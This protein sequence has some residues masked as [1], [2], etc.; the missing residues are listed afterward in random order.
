MKLFFSLFAIL[1]CC[2][3]TA[4]IPDPNNPLVQQRARQELVDRGLTEAE[5]RQRLEAEGID[6]DNARPDQL[7]RIQE[8]IDEMEAE[9]KN[10]GTGI[11]RPGEPRAAPPTTPQP[12]SKPPSKSS[13][14]PLPSQFTPNAAKSI[15]RAI[16]DGAT[17]QEAISEE[18]IDAAAEQDTSLTQEARIYGH[19]FFRNQN[20]S[21]FRQS[22]NVKV[23]PS[24]ILGAG[25]EI[26][27][28]IFGPSVESFTYE[29]SPG[30]FIQPTQMPRITLKGVTIEEARAILRRQFSRFYVFGTG[31]FV[32]TLNTARTIRVNIYGEVLRRGS[33]TV[34]AINNAYNALAAS[35]G[36]SDIG[37]VRNIQINR[38]AESSTTVDL[39]DFLIAGNPIT[40][41]LALD[42]NDY[43]FVPV[44]DRVV[45]IEGAVQR[46]FAYELKAG[47]QL[48]TLLRFAG[49]LAE[50][51]YAG[52]ITVRRFAG[53]RQVVLDVD[54]ETLRSSGADFT[55]KPGDRVRV[56]QQSVRLRGSAQV[57]GAV[58][59]PDSYGVGENLRLTQ[60]LQ[61]AV[62]AE[63]AQRQFVFLQRLNP[64]STYNFQSVALAAA[65]AA[66]G[67]T[68]DVNIQEGDIV[69]VLSQIR[70]SALGTIRVQGAVENPI[71][72]FP[73]DAS[74]TLR[75]SDAIY[76]A[77]GL[78]PDATS[79]AY[80]FRTDPTNPSLKQYIGVDI[81][82]IMANP[83]R[84][85]NII[86]QA[87]DIVRI[88]DR[89]RYTDRLT[90]QVSGEVRQPDEFAFAEGATLRDAI[91]LAG[92]LLF[93]ADPSR[94]EVFRTVIREGESVQT[95]AA[96]V[97]VDVDVETTTAADFL[98]EPFDKIYV[99]RIP[100][101]DLEE[102]IYIG[103]EVRY[104]GN[105]P[106]LRDNERLVDVI[107]RAGGLTDE[108]FPPGATL[109][110]NE[111]EVG[112]IVM[113]LERALDDPAVIDNI[114]LREG[115][116]I[117]IPKSKDLVI[118]QGA[119][120]AGEF[121]PG[122]VT[123]DGRI[124]TAYR[125]NGKRAR[126]YLNE[127][128][129][130]PAENAD[131]RRIAVLHP[132]GEIKRTKNI[133]FFRVTPKV[134]RGSIVTVPVKP[135]KIQDPN[136]PDR[137]K[138]DWGKVIADSI[139]QATAILSLVLLVQQV[140]R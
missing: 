140:N 116:Q 106:L 133:L 6:L 7:P 74:G 8:I 22:D 85:D 59:Y 94:V 83:D 66:P 69:T 19:Q 51:A 3:L 48:N 97:D 127:F 115:D 132:N 138:V 21:V 136:D 107:Q 46:P 80:V 137:E 40:N 9:K 30:G 134:R 39:Y 36:P 16:E 35:G 23:D 77:G 41:E 122:V 82:E 124:A 108:A 57:T 37:S 99:R 14:P 18:L 95:V 93:E 4:Q 98:L 17:V 79:F 20:I 24:Y 1:F 130:G 123:A 55:L 120:D 125:G 68:A 27:V 31:Q 10:G 86:L 81:L 128:A 29:I 119:T 11:L 112:F 129:G 121:Y 118:I 139:G 62:L 25:D 91:R 104:P 15:E 52:G 38:T 45:T 32:V 76:L 33:Y 2:H 5:V 90:F 105:Y 60:L 75:V 58:V 110:R 70:R 26:T 54:Y 64:D 78:M 12:A 87:G 101:F 102:V 126:Y 65:L 84:V 44:A 28:Q 53:D 63:D 100:Q 92:G 49:G 111:Q 73:F 88:F 56:P 61:R 131:R 96:T 103:G 117:T 71:D 43:I 113:D 47:E 13:Q 114:I 89:T 50:N 109:Y 42:N 72:S 34:S 67:S 135:P